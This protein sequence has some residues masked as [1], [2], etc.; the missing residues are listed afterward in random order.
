MHCWM[1]KGEI[2]SDL[3]LWEPTHEQAR[4][5]RPYIT[6]VDQLLK[7]TNCTQLEELKTAM[8]EKD[9]WR[10]VVTVRVKSPPG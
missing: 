6:Y 3:L 5:G 9:L 1:S 4:P 8:E 10:R 2:V 7:E